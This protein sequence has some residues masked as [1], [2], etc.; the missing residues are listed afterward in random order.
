MKPP[1]PA[2][3]YAGLYVLLCEIAR[4]HGYALAIHGTM[5]NDLDVVAIPWTDEAICAEKLARIFFDKL[6]WL[7]HQPL[8]DYEPE[9]KSHGRVAYKIPLFPGPACVDLSIMPRSLK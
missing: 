3:A 9:Q 5:I 4:K 1:T 6:F 2:P 7:H 8:P